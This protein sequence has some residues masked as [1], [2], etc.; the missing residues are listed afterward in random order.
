MRQPFGWHEPVLPLQPISGL[1]ETVVRWRR[2]GLR[3]VLASDQSARLSEI[4][5]EADIMAAP[6]ATLREAP[7]AGGLALIERSLNSGFAGGPEGVVLVT[8]RELF[9]TVRVRRPRVLRRIVPK[10]LL[11]RLQPSDLVVHIDHGIARYAVMVRRNAGGDG[12]DERDFLELHFAGRGRIWVPVEQ[13]ERV[14]RYAGGREPAPVAPRRREWQRTKTRVRKAVTDLAKDLLS[15]YSA[16]ERARDDRWPRLALAAGME[17]AFPYEETVDQLKPPR[18]SRTPGARAADGPLVVGDVGYGK[19]EVALPRR[20]GHGRR[21]AGCRPRA[22]DRA[23]VAAPRDVPPALRRVPISRCACCPLRRPS[24]QDDRRGLAAGSV[25]LVIGTH[26]LLSKDIVFRNLVSSWSTK[27][28]ARRR[29]QGALKQMRTEVQSSRVRDA[30]PAQLNLALA[31]VRDMS[32]RD[33]RETDYRSRRASRRLRPVS[34]ATRSCAS[35]T[36]AGRSSSSTTGSRLRGPGR[37]A[38]P[39]PARGAH[40]GRPRRWARGSSRR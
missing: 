1:A 40:R 26:R 29:P 6:M 13:I 22:D 8:D 19:T 24:H 9:G 32:S 14:T 18:R 11:E 30:D 2:E 31:G 15:L 28:S 20:S 38:A 39:A 3:V 35:S 21:D 4:L 36:A 16:R 37:A 34:Y 7:P 23:R 12:P 33:P 17:A 25:D 5:G 27:S 10:D